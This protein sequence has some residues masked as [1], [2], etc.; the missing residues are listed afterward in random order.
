MYR[1]TPDGLQVLLVHP[2]G[3]FWKHK[4][5]GAWSIPKGEVCEGEELLACA[6]RE[7]QEETGFVPSGN[8]LP[9]KPIKQKSGKIVHAWAFE[10]DGDPSAIR[11][12]TFTIEWPP[13]S[14]KHIRIPEV[15][16]A[17]FFD[18]NLARQKINPAQAAFID[19]LIDL[20]R[21]T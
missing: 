12:N 21:A 6:Q 16:R 11:S 1:R 14:G 18:M 19:Q 17:D 3:P 13:K 20:L 8:F 15:D 4:D 10:G 7:F 9:L 2:G 5:E